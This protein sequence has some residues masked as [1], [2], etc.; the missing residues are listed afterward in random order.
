MILQNP[1]V[2][3]K[4]K[5]GAVKEVSPLSEQGT[6]RALLHPLF[7]AKLLPSEQYLTKNN[8]LTG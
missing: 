5:D 2:T 8:S 1:E 4:V 7:T 6:F 3:V